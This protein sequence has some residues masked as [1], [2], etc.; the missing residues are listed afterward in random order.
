MER[1]H[2]ELRH[3]RYRR[4][5]GQNFWR[6]VRGE[7][8]PAKLV[9]EPETSNGGKSY[10]KIYAQC[11]HATVEAGAAWPKIANNEKARPYLDVKLNSPGLSGAFYGKLFPTELVN[12]QH[13][14]LW[15]ESRAVPNATP[16]AGSTVR[17]AAH[18]TP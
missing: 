17:H 10:Y 3:I 18:L 14:L 6:D 8:V 16:S 7:Y 12:G 15:D 9:F 13:Q 1:K 4:E 5:D 2:V 11:Q